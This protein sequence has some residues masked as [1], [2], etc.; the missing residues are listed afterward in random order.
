MNLNDELTD[1][2]DLIDRINVK[3]EDTQFKIG[4]QNKDMNKILGKK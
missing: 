3:T 4:K 1:H 2:N